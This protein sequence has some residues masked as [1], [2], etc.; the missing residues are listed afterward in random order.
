[1][2]RICFPSRGLAGHASAGSTLHEAVRALGHVID[3][4]C[5]G[6]ALCGTCCVIVVEG[7]AALTPPGPEESCRLKELGVG[8]P[9]RLSCQARLRQCEREVTIVGC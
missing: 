2:P 1:M 5:G 9:H 8:A 6:N 3:Y 4:A 7:E